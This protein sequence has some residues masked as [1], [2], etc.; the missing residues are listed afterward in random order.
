MDIKIKKQLLEDAKQS[1]EKLSLA[2][3]SEYHP[4]CEIGTLVEGGH[5]PEVY[6]LITEELEA[7]RMPTMLERLKEERIM[8]V[9]MGEDGS[10]T[11]TEACDKYFDI[12]LSAGELRQLAIE[13]LQ[14]ANH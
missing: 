10:F 4:P 1:I 13:L 6:G 2:I 3:W 7:V 9:E 5:M 8:I 12:G 11:L 14:M